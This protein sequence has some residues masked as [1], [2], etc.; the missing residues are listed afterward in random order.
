MAKE[1]LEK[2][3]ATLIY[4]LPPFFFA[5]LALISRSAASR[6]AARTSGF[7]LRFLESTCVHVNNAQFTR[8]SPVR[9][10]RSGTTVSARSRVS[11]ARRVIS[12]ARRS[13]A[14]DAVTS[15]EIEP[16]VIDHR[17]RSTFDPS[18]VSV[19]SPR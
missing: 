16:N 4:F 18:R 7:S 2:E 19:A 14:R 8:Q 17:T 6:A 5:A 3:D 11:R 10:R 13:S 12:L 1:I 15:S 9:S